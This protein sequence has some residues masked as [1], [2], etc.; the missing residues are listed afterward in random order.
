MSGAVRATDGTLAVPVIG[1]FIERTNFREDQA[2]I[3]YGIYQHRVGWG[4]AWEHLL[5]HE[6]VAW[7]EVVECF[8]TDPECE[9]GTSLLC[10]DC[11]R[12]ELRGLLAEMAVE[13]DPESEEQRVC[14]VCGC[15]DDKPCVAGCSWAGEDLCTACVDKV[16]LVFS[17][18][19]MNAYIA[20]LR[21]VAP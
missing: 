3:C 13:D 14:R 19:E 5:E 8:Q 4:T 10:V 11:N 9:C 7:R 18:S 1:S 16:P 20:L 6:R 2:R 21:A 17:E 15:T 12:A